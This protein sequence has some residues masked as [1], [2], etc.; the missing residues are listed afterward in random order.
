MDE[1]MTNFLSV[2]NPTVIALKQKLGWWPMP[3]FDFR[4]WLGGL[5]VFVCLLLLLTPFMSRGAR[6]M[7]P[8]AYFLIVIMILNALGHILFS[9][10]GRT[11]D[12]VHFARPAPGFYSSPFLL[13]A[14]I[15]LLF[16]LR[17][18]RQYLA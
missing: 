13:A 12:S 10:L 5:I 6:W 2:Y 9:I 7:R 18:S 3:T 1:A 17:N 8:I 4:S 14:S 11:V 16:E 15:Y